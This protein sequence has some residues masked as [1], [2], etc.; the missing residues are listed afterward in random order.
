MA[1][2][3]V[4]RLPPRKEVGRRSERSCGQ[5]W[6]GDMPGLAYG[7]WWC[8]VEVSGAEAI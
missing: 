8:V 3:V 5:S 4:S 1:V 2:S 6:V 7:W